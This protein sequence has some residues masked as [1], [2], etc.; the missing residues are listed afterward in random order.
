V[1]FAAISL[2][3]GEWIE[4]GWATAPTSSSTSRATTSDESGLRF[5]KI[6][7]GDTDADPD[8]EGATD[9]HAGHGH[10]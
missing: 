9:I 5:P 6:F 3:L 8:G 4:P 2:A 7:G 10:A 1:D